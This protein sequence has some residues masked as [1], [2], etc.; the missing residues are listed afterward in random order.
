MQD[1]QP[2]A[3][4]HDLL[5]VVFYEDDSDAARGRLGDQ[6]DLLRSLRLVETGDGFVQQYHLRVEGERA[7]QFEPLHLSERQ[8]AGE[9]AFGAG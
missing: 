8:G 5:E 2:P 3:D 7:S 9:L 4:A 6:L 1:H